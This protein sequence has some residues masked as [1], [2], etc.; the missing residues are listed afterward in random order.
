MYHILA[1]IQKTEVK[2]SL[3][4]KSGPSANVRIQQET[5]VNVA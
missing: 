4:V 2:S 5:C 1:G 3:S